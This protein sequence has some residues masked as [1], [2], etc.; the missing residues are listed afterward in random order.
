ML[1]KMG[2]REGQGIGVAGQGCVE[3]VGLNLKA[4]RAGLGIDED[5]KRRKDCAQSQQDE[6]GAELSHTERA[7]RDE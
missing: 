4:S 7:P 2:Y 1:S 5:R 3:P 6:K